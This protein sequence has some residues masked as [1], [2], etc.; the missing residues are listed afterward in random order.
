MRTEAW[1]K[2]GLNAALASWT[3][4]RH[5]TILYAKQSYTPGYTG[6]YPPP[7]PPPPPPPGY[8]EPVPEFYG[9]LL[10]LTQMTR[11]GLSDYNVLSA[12]ATERLI[13]LE[14]ILNRLIE[15]A[16][17]ELT[18]QELSE[19]EHSYIRGL[20]KMLERAVIGVE[21]KGIKTILVADVHT[22]IA[23][24]K[25]VEEGVGYVNLIIV[26]CPAPDGSIFLAAGPVLSYYE[27]KHPMDDRLTDEAWRELLASPAKP[28]RPRWFQ[29]LM[30]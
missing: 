12:K 11:E 29:P 10:A 3:E 6:P 15:I 19:N 2:K 22:H 21:E 13:N 20:A 27:F 16:N 30:P 8:V 18:N 25:V 23:E 4:L 17:K 28:A 9:R 24:K 1:D 26:A 14:N 7:P 5:D